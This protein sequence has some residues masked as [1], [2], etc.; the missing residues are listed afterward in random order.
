MAYLDIIRDEDL[1]EV[2]HLQH[3]GCIVVAD[4][5]ALQHILG[6]GHLPGQPALSEGSV[7]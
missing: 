1:T 2:E 4:A 5:V 3:G 7:E 6:G